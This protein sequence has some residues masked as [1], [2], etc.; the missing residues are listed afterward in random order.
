MMKLL[1]GNF[2]DFVIGFSFSSLPQMKGNRRNISFFRYSNILFAEFRISTD[3]FIKC[4]EK[5]QAISG[6]CI[7]ENFKIDREGLSNFLVEP[8]FLNDF[9]NESLLMY[10]A[11]PYE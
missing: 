4:L 9:F 8:V 3:D 6:N 7:V 1:D 11:L 5:L 2:T 10:I